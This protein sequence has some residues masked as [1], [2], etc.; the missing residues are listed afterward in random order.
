M[1][2]SMGTTL[3]CQK[4]LLT[5]SVYSIPPKHVAQ[6][7]GVSRSLVARVISA[8]DSYAGTDEFWARVERHFPDIIAGRQRVVF[9]QPAAVAV[10]KLAELRQAS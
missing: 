8:N 7:V 1:M 5:L 4:L 10:G 3:N 9:E 6:T 2:A